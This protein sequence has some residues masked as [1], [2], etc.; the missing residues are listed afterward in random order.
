MD[1]F[2]LSDAYFAR[3]GEWFPTMEF[4]ADSVD[5]IMMKMRECLSKGIPAEELYN[6]SKDDTANY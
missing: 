4:Q 1:Y 2:E 5:D 6:L 3:F